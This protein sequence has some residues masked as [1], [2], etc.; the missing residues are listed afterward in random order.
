MM[1]LPNESLSTASII[2]EFRA[3]WNEIQRNYNLNF[4][5]HQRSQ[6]FE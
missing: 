4:K 2:Y 3:V 6:L 5:V 1:V